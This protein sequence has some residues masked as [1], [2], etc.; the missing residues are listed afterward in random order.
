MTLWGPPRDVRIPHKMFR[1]ETAESSQSH[2][3]SAWEAGSSGWTAKPGGSTEGYSTCCRH[4]GKINNDQQIV[5]TGKMFLLQI[6][7]PQ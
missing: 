7:Q 1:P 5:K 6:K 3:S 4:A 2:E